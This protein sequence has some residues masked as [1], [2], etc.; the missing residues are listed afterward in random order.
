MRRLLL[1]VALI[2][3]LFGAIGALPVAAEPQP[4]TT[5][6]IFAV[7]PGRVNNNVDSV[8]TITGVGF[9]ATPVVTLNSRD[10]APIVLNDIE[11][12]SNV[13]IRATV[14]A[15]TVEGIYDVIVYN[16]DGGE[17]NRLADALMVVRPGDGE[18]SDWMETLAIL[19]GRVE[20]GAVAVGDQLYLIGGCPSNSTLAVRSVLQATIGTDGM[21]GAWQT[22]AALR[23]ARCAVSTVVHGEYIYVIGG[24]IA[25]GIP[26][27][28]SIERSRVNADGTLGQWELVGQLPEVRFSAAAV[29]VDDYL[30]VMD[31]WASWSSENPPADSIRAQIAADGSLGGWEVVAA[32]AGESQMAVR[33]NEFIFV[34][35]GDGSIE[36]SRVQADGSLAPWVYVPA[37]QVAHQRG[38][39]AVLDGTLLVL[40][41]IRG[42]YPNQYMIVHVE[43]AALAEDGTL[44]AW[45]FAPSMLNAR[46]TFPVATAGNRLYAIGG[47]LYPEDVRAIEVIQKTV[48]MTERLYLPLMNAV[49]G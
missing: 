31:G 21:L 13:R 29:V 42:T 24:A 28:K 44:G 14:P 46:A 16:P 6:T 9:A 1:F 38:A 25:S 15:E 43:K 40:G 37:T 17:S 8:I 45:S 36:R 12:I 23:N 41:G 22:T 30:Y 49:G 10:Q 2:G 20:P 3:G 26:A 32:T 47:S 19:D 48:A 11:F 7:S 39:L 4:A 34:L 27:E 35:N 5:P 18:L 33:H